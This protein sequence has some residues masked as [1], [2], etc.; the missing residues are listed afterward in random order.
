MKWLIL[1]L[2]IASNAA[3]SIIIKYAGNNINFSELLRNPWNVLLNYPLLL[4]VFF[5]FIAFI[6]YVLALKAFP[7]HIAH[8]ILTSGAIAVVAIFAFLFF[9]EPF[10]MTKLF[11]ILCIL[12]GVV[13][14][15]RG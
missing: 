15:A 4:G 3:A 7:L 2:G 6:L 8:P 1:T 14:L 10:S 13:A 12:I 11:G 9:K 5:Y